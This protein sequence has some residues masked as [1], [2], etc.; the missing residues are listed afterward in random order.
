MTRLQQDLNMHGVRF[1]NFVNLSEEEKQT[2]LA[3]RNHERVR[4][5][6]FTKDIISYDQHRVFLNKL[7]VATDKGYW[8]VQQNNR[9]IGVVDVYNATP[10]Q[11]YWGYYLNPDQLGG[12]YGILL[13]YLILEIGFYHLDL[14]S[15][16]CESLL[17]NKSVIK[18]HQFFGYT[19]VEERNG[20][21]IQTIDRKQFERQQPLYEQ[22]TRKFFE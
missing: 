1:I 10:E 14:T 8:M 2:V 9:N 16:W 19:T 11:A 5:M 4:S 7:S 12:G 3:W 18:T 15:L 22:L 20:C 13:E 6:M 17:V 21:S